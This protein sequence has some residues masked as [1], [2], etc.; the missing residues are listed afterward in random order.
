MEKDLIKAE[1]VPLLEGDTVRIVITEKED[2]S[3]I[4]HT[5]VKE[6]LELTPAQMVGLL[7]VS[8]FDILAQQ[9]TRN[10]QEPVQ[11]EDHG[12][13]PADVEPTDVELVE[14]DFET[15]PEL[16]THM[17]FNAGETVQLPKM[18]VQRLIEAR[19]K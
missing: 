6:G 17:K 13:N 10:S 11:E 16:K 5:S 8:K 1:E 19:E 12:I 2:G 4:L 3:I 9:T 14:K 18:T 7:E 15:F